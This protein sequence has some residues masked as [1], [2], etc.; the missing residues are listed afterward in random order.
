[1]SGR[2]LIVDPMLPNR[3]MLKAQIS[4]D[5]FQ[6]AAVGDAAEMARQLAS[7]PPDVV[8]L[9]WTAAREADFTQIALIRATPARAHLPVVL[10]HSGQDDAAVWDDCHR[11]H[12]DEVISY[13]AP[14]WLISA[15]L[16][17][18]VRTKEKID[19]MR[20]RQ[21]TLGDMGFAEDH[22][23][24][25]P[26]GALSLSLDLSRAGLSVDDTRALTRCL[27]LDF[28]RVTVRDDGQ[29]AALAV[30]DEATLGRDVAC[31]A[32]ATRRKETMARAEKA[33]QATSPGGTLYVTRAASRSQVRDALELGADDV[34]QGPAGLAELA[35]RLRRLAWHQALH[36]AADRA[37]SNHLQSALKD[38]LTGLYNRRYAG[39]YLSRLLDGTG[40]DDWITVMMLD[41]DN[42]KSVNDRFG[43]AAGDTVLREVAVRLGDNLRG[44]DLLAR[45]GGEEFLIVIA[46]LADDR[47][48]AIAERLRAEVAARPFLASPDL[49]I[50]LSVSI[51]VAQTR[52][53][54][55][56]ADVDKMLT[57]ADDALYDAKHAGRNRVT[58]A[59]VAA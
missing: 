2:V 48:R 45:V 51:G 55:G 44:S 38:P 9:S 15:R 37:M 52:R 20:A 54:N 21:R 30:I 34:L 7:D 33:G 5:F 32:L 53:C 24:Y 26:A 58:F 17:Q 16:N 35:T 25:P 36:A 28:A 8:L 13:D 39:G 1:M 59:A 6:V 42:F 10:L 57:R 11:H 47:A 49:A 4:R 41:L 23:P 40:P 19:A 43:H 12:A 3:V 14:R 31:R 18:L 22:A 46:G 50:P 29:I 56:A 27:S